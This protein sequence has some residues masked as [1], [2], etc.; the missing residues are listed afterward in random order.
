MNYLGRASG[1]MAAFALAGCAGSTTM[2]D[3]RSEPAEKG[4]PL[5]VER[6]FAEPDLA[7]PAPKNRKI[8]PDGSRVGF[9][10]GR[11]DDKLTLDLWSYDIA[12]NEVRRL[13][14]AN[15]L[16]GGVSVL[17]AEEEARRERQRTAALKGIV[18]YAFAPSGDQLLFPLNGDLYLHDLGSREPVRW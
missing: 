10:R 15:A 7:G 13:V 18:D 17:S 4:P 5:T 2:S 9:L 11:V 8:S 16:T 14:D 6:L 12:T 1:M 3:A